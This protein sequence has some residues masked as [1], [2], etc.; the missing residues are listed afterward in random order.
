[1]EVLNMIIDCSQIENKSQLHV[2]L[3]EKLEFPAYYGH[4]L[5]AL[6]DC[7]TSIC[8]D[9]TLCLTGWGSLGDWKEGFENV[10]HYAMEE[11]PHLTIRLECKM[12]NA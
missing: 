5:D 2:L 12:Q 8:R 4:N 11:N 6:M 7:L 10:F 9:L 3:A 1:M